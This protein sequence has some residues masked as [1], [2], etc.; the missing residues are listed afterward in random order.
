MQ[1]SHLLLGSQLDNTNATNNK[2]LT[3]YMRSDIDMRRDSAV[4]IRADHY[5]A[6]SSTANVRERLDFC[7]FAYSV[8]AAKHIGDTIRYDSV[9]LKARL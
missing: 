1:S 9:Y 7:Y 5:F 8:I 6:N 3:I 4:F 2:N